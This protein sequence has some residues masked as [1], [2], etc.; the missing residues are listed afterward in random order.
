MSK[1]LLVL[2]HEI[3]TTIARRSFILMALGVPLVG[4][5]FMLGVS[6]LNSRPD[7]QATGVVS[8]LFSGQS[9]RSGL[10]E[11]YVDE[12]GIL[13]TI[14]EG[15]P[16]GQFLPY[17]D[18]ERAEQAVRAGEIGAYY[19]IPPDFMETGEVVY[20]RPDF[21]PLSAFDQ[22]EEM[23]WILTVNLLGGDE[24]L[25]SLVNQPLETETV[26]L[27]PTPE[28]DEEN[29]LTFFLPYAVTLLFYFVIIMSSSFLLNSVTK[30]KENRVLEILMI[31]ATPRQLLMGK[32][33]GLGVVGLLQT[34]IWGGTAFT[35][36]R[37]SGRTLDIPAAFQL[38]PSILFWGLIFFLLGYAV[39]AS[40]M[41]SVGALVPNLREASQATFVVILPLIIPLMLISV[42]IQEPNG[43]L[44]TALSLFP[45]TSPVVMMTRLA[46]GPV[47][48]W[49]PVLAAVL[50]LVTSVFIIRSTA[51]LFRA[52]TLLSGQP[53]KMGAFFRALAGRG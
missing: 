11:G 49:Q 5:L 2:K 50:L 28:R 15:I 45:L 12:A 38:P 23:Q 19:L 33:S 8:N 52:Q 43:A 14:P 6:Y 30:E 48:V 18:Q 16:A 40:L 24:A 32:I 44:A 10:P 46:A 31:S 9:E 7:S 21:N 41:A 3:I 51:N 42:L 22:S 20:I 13:Q 35:L 27:A 36:L 25:A 47:P 29:P 1:T 17:P 37:L 34:I 53:F 39:Y 26:S 4:A